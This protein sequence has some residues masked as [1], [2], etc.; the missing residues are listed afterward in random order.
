MVNASPP[1]PTARRQRAT[2][3]RARFRQVAWAFVPVLS[4]SLLA[5]APFLWL[6]LIRRQARDWAVAAAYVTAVVV[7]LVLIFISADK[8]GSVASDIAT[9]MIL[10]LVVTATVHALV[11]FRPAAGLPSWRDVHAIRA[12][13][14]RAIRR[15]KLAEA[16]ARRSEVHARATEARSAMAG[17]DQVQKGDKATAQAAR[18]EARSARKAERAA[19]RAAATEAKQSRRREAAAG[20]APA[21]AAPAEPKQSR[22]REAVAARAAERR[23]KRDAAIAAKLAEPRYGWVE[24][25]RTYRSKTIFGNR[26]SETIVSLPSE[27]N[28]RR[29]TRQRGGV[30]IT[31]E[32][33]PLD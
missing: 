22:R 1:G 19:A 12:A 10:P 26:R 25:R 8:T 16:D 30:T 31:E 24:T 15:Q 33:R 2:G 32:W 5:F 7:E 3:A 21:Q 14:K 9:A 17:Q 23:K 13:G 28:A 27:R 11:A 6:A 20:R 18:A 4:L 29:R